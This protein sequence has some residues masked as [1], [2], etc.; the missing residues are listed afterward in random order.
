VQA[1]GGVVDKYIGDCLMVLWG[2]PSLITLPNLRAC[3]AALAMDRATK[4]GVLQE[5]FS[6]GREAL[7]IR[8]GIHYGE[9]LAG[10]MGTLTRV[11]YTVIG[12]P[13]NTAARLEAV[14]KDFG[15]R[16]LA[17]EDVVNAAEVGMKEL[18]LRQITNV[19][20]V[21]REMPLRVYEIVGMKPE[22]DDAADEA[23]GN[24]QQEPPAAVPNAAA[25]AVPSTLP[26]AAGAVGRPQAEEVVVVD[27]AANE[28]APAAGVGQQAVPRAVP[29]PSLGPLSN[30]LQP[31]SSLDL[32]D[33][34][35]VPKAEE[36]PQVVPVAGI[37]PEIDDSAA[38]E[39]NAS[40]L[41]SPIL[42]AAVGVVS[43]RQAAR[44]PSYQIIDLSVPLGPPSN[45]LQPPESG[46]EE[47]GR[48]RS[49]ENSPLPSPNSMAQRQALWE[50]RLS[51]RI[52]ALQD[53]L[54][55]GDGV[56]EAA[57]LSPTSKALHEMASEALRE[58]EDIIEDT[59][60][61]TR[62][63]TLCHVVSREEAQWAK[64]FSDAVESYVQ[65]DFDTALDLLQAALAK[66][67]VEDDKEILRTMIKD[68]Q[69]L[70]TGVVEGKHK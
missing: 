40:A 45:V 15:T 39:P 31:P 26:V 7:M 14:N 3:C 9:C 8:T 30:V 70:R 62:A 35:S 46:E 34:K 4:L 61:L 41:P 44:R 58:V 59:D 27:L 1:F 28:V 53:V 51:Q 20:V 48:N 33:S 69:G 50:R 18:V 32:A 43:R 23:A 63:R 2:A 66:A 12:D 17:S 47:A 29:P 42:S 57:P 52:R 25:L 13:V 56:P 49:S 65:R 64:E 60:L 11:N 21:G 67:V 55:L 16:I 36:G 37:N 10:N 6:L 24:G 19:R 5:L 38:A 22:K 68:C 54:P